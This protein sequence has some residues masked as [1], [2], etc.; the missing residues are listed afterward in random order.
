MVALESVQAS[1]AS[2]KSTSPGQIALFIGATS[3]IAMH[4]LLEYARHSNSPKVYLVGR[5]ESKLS[6]LINQLV[7]INP[8][9][10]YTPLQYSI[11]LLKNVDA[12]CE[13]FKRNEKSLHLLV[14]CPGYLKVSR[15]GG[16]QFF[17]LGTTSPLN[18]DTA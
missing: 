7:K 13:E 8:Q 17:F 6:P 15:V 18:I 5:S 2:L 14:M 3:G 1:N 16:Y 10:S 4:T 9:G 11:S 12:A